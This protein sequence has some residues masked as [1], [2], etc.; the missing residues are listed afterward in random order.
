MIQ[1]FINYPDIASKIDETKALYTVTHGWIDNVNRTWVGATIKDLVAIFDVNACGVDW[2][3]L[4]NYE[5]SISATKHVQIVVDYLAKFIEYLVSLG[6]KFDNVNMV[7]HSLG[8]QISGH[9]GMRLGGK[10]AT[11]YGLDPA[12][13]L[14]CQPI[15][16][17]IDKRLDPSDAKF[18][19]VIHTTDGILGCGTDQG[20]Q[21]F[22]PDSGLAPQTAC[23]LPI[24]SETLSPEIISCSHAQAIQ[25]FHFS[26]NS[27]N[28]FIGRRCS[29]ATLF[30]ILAC[31][32]N[33]TD[34]LGP[35]TDRLPGKFYLKT[36]FS[37]PFV[38]K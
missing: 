35:F 37:A 8:G 9:A 36:S 18:V 30:N 38:P 15:L 6:I 3:K 26:L 16:K 27:I 32:S 17:D 5:Y 33:P 28:M 21:D 2:S 34:I 7:G 12:G 25:Y 13:P 31:K 22:H 4:A 11:I 23:L 24:A 20:H 1:T 29:S 10:V 19:Q 14:F